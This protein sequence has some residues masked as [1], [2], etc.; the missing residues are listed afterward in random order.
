[1]DSPTPGREP[2]LPQGPGPHELAEIPGGESPP[3]RTPAADELFRALG[4]TR[5]LADAPGDEPPSSADLGAPAVEATRAAPP[6]GADR[7]A[8]D[9]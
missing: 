8:R 3:D 7:A 2:T 9:W 6:A 1:M 4:R 5:V